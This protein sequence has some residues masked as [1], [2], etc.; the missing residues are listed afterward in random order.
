MA[1]N[2]AVLHAGPGNEWWYDA[3]LQRIHLKIVTGGFGTTVDDGLRSTF[4]VNQ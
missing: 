4:V 2:A 3:N 1:A